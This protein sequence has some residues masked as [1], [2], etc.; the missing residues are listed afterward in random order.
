[1]YFSI[2]SA[3]LCASIANAA[4]A[5]NGNAALCGRLYSQ[6]TTIGTHD[7]Y[8]FSGNTQDMIDLL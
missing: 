8:D 1:M 7:R 2:L 5:C 6:V 4:T 3:L